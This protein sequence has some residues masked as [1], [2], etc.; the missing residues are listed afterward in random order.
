MGLILAR[1]FQIF[2][3]VLSFI[4]IIDVFMSYFLS[5]NNSIRAFFDRLVE[6]LL[7][8]IRRVMPSIA[9]LD[10]SPIVLIILLSVL[11][12]VLVS[13]VSGL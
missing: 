10:F 9:G 3:E 12:S 2:F 4:V 13:L 6:P 1:S 11:E 7:S 5:P 8:P